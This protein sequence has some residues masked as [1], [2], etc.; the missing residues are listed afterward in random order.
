M[1]TP[2]YL[3]SFTLT[4]CVT[5]AG[6]IGVHANADEPAKPMVLRSV[7]QQLDRDMQSVT[8]AIAREDWQRVAELAPKIGDHPAPPL[9]EKLRILKWLGSDAGSFRSFDRQV[10]D[11][12]DAMGE[13]AAHGDGASVIDSFARIQHGC[14]ECHQRFRKPFVAHFH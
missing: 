10:H 12:A 11:A 7:M 1:Q 9:G 6:F 2:G 14:L 5:L 4:L 3:R 8:A 13:G